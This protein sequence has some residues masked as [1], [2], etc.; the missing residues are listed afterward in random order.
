[1]A[2]YRLQDWTVGHYAGTERQPA[3]AEVMLQGTGAKGF[4]RRRAAAHEE[5][6][7][8]ELLPTDT[9]DRKGSQALVTR[10][11]AQSAGRWKGKP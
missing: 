7:H 3:Y 1:M 6:A 4:L 2:R 5:R 10:A 8:I 9:A 11:M